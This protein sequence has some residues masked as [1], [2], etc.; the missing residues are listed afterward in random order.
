[1]SDRPEVPQEVYHFVMEAPEEI[2][3]LLARACAVVTKNHPHLSGDEIVE[4]ASLVIQQSAAMQEM[5][6]D[7]EL[8]FED[9]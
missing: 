6:I 3:G 1:M 9:E 5:N 4:H 8:Y 2:Q 7:P